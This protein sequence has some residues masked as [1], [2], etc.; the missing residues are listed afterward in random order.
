MSKSVLPRAPS[1]RRRRG[2]VTSAFMA[3]ALIGTALAAPVAAAP[4]T[5]TVDGTL[6]TGPTSL[7][8]KSYVIDVFGTLLVSATAELSQPVRE[9]LDWDGQTSARV[10]PWTWSGRSRRTVRAR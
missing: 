1:G 7:G 4:Q 10:A 6:H 8:S 2:R 9:T 5:A 3:A